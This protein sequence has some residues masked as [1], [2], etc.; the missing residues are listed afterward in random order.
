[1]LALREIRKYQRSTYLLIKK[2]P[3]QQF[4]RDTITSTIIVLHEFDVL[5]AYLLV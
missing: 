1:M 2:V 5:I 4:G 3:F